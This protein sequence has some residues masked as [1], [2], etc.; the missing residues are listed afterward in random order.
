MGRIEYKDRRSG[1]SALLAFVLEA[2]K[3]K[4]SSNGL[5]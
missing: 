1:E 5:A 3:M 2:K 4:A